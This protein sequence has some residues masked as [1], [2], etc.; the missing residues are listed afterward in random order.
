MSGLDLE[1][2]PLE[3]LPG[4]GPKTAGKLAGGGLERIADLLTVVPAGYRDRRRP[5]APGAVEIEGPLAVRGT[6]EAPR[7]IH[8]RGRGRR[9]SLLLA[10][11]TGGGGSVDVR[12]HNQPYLMQRLEEGSE[13]LLCG[14]VRQGRGGFEML[15][16]A[17]EDPE[18]E[19]PAVTPVYP[20]TA[21]LGP[22]RMATL[23]EAVLDRLKPLPKLPDPLPENLLKRRE[24]PALGAALEEV[25]RP[26][27]SCEVEL[28]RRRGTPGWY[29]LVYGELVER[30][31]ALEELRQRRRELEK[32]RSPGLDEASRR[33]RRLDLRNLAPFSLTS[34]Q[35]TALEEI[36]DDL[37][38]P[39][40]M[41]R[42]LQGDVASGKTAVALLTAAAVLR[43]GCSVALMA[44]TELLAEQHHATA[45]RWLAGMAEVMLVTAAEAGALPTSDAPRLFVGTH[46]LIHRDDL[47]SFG[48]VIIDEQHRFGV[49]QRRRLV[50]GEDRPDLLLMSATPIPRSLAL[51]LHGD[52]EI[53]VLDHGPPGRSPVT[54]ELWP[55]RQRRTL[56]RR[57][58]ARLD[59]GAQI[60]AVF[61]TIE[62]GRG[63]S[64]LMTALERLEKA[65]TPHAG[66]VLHGRLSREEQR[67]AVQGFA[68]GEVR[69]LAATTVVEVGLDVES[70]TVMLIEAAES[71]GLAQLHQLRGRVGRG[72]EPGFCY[73]VHGPLQENARRRLEAFAGTG[74]GFE[75]ARLDLEQRG[76]GDLLGARQAGR[77]GLRAADLGR[78][79]R[80]LERAAEDAPELRARLA[81]G[82][83]PALA[84]RVAARLERLGAEIAA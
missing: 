68:S 52:V 14:D 2:E 4:V 75:L 46:A 73:A 45:Q 71:F 66:A 56:L 53:S 47:P 3:V 36:L 41:V 72:A 48:L 33:D 9:R 28:L 31:L 50:E 76:P 44:P 42:L 79:Q 22:A 21:D 58:K 57:L 80:W 54:T 69:W 70:A 82:E 83:L 13:V 6:L 1:D 15:N 29:R 20:R 43:Q 63:E 24:L 74:D 7:L 35:E 5:L 26:S 84:R 30:Q 49:D 81:A 39:F 51:A 34:P 19:G 17:L 32:R 78:D 16:P 18:G 37:E 67:R 8:P 65:W 11:V 12:W 64:R 27:E 25:H 10:R 77:E 59:E 62:G 38:R 55:R 61:P 40:P 60:Y 23:M